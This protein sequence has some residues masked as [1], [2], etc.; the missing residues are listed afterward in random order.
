MGKFS[1]KLASAVAVVPLMMAAATVKAQQINVGAAS[2]IGGMVVFVAQDKGFFAKH[3]IDAKVGVRNTG[4]ALSKSL[5]AGEL[6]IALAAFTN[7]PAA[8]ERGL[9]LS[10]HSPDDSQT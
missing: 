3:G 6:D 8:L 7:I 9:V 5:R 1:I 10:R 2:N 4:A